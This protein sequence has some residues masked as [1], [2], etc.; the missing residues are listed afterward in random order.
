MSD[1]RRPSDALTARFESDIAVVFESMNIFAPETERR[2]IEAIYS[3]ITNTIWTDGWSDSDDTEILLGFRAASALVHSASKS[4]GNPNQ[5]YGCAEEGV[6]YKPFAAA[7]ARM[8][9]MHRSAWDD[10][11]AA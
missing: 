4:Y 10:E 8:G 6:V 11:V 5:Y 1:P 7:M 2:A 3:S 9:W